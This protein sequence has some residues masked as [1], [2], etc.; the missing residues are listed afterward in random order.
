MTARRCRGSVV[1][2]QSS[3]LHS[4]RRQK[5][6]NRSAMRS[7]HAWGVEPV[8]LGGLR[9]PP[10]ECSSIPMRK[11]TCVAAEPAVAGDAVGAHLLERV[12]EVGVA[13]GVVDGGG[14]VELR[15][16][17]GSTRSPAAGGAAAPGRRRRRLAD[18]APSAAH[19]R[20]SGCAASA[21]TGGGVLG[22]LPATSAAWPATA[23]A[24]SRSAPCDFLAELDQRDD[25]RA[26]LLAPEEDPLAEDV[27][28]DHLLGA[29]RRPT[30]LPSLGKRLPRARRR[31]R[32]RT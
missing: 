23:A 11:W 16:L 20:S 10:G 3:L 5:L 6:S 9:A 27:H 31:T 29:R 14:E 30:V 22:A 8:V 7:T 15:P 4:S 25:P 19:G 18:A 13:V 21:A 17:G 12:A 32:A 24:R 1:R 2:I 26:V 28:R